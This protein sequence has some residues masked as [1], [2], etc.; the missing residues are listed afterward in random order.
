MKKVLVWILI[1][2]LFS[3]IVYAFFSDEPFI[4]AIGKFFGIILPSL[5]NLI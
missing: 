4:K 2:L 5:K 3:A 1:G